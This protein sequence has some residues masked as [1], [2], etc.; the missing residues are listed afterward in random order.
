[1][2]TPDVATLQCRNYGATKIDHVYKDGAFIR[3][4]VTF[5]NIHAAA[6]FENTMTHVDEMFGAIANSVFL[7]TS[8]SNFH[9]A[10]TVSVGWNAAY[11]DAVT[12]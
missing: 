9:Q 8:V 10:V 5:P 11:G 1:M 4:I 3:T 6:S 7:A 12:A 2:I